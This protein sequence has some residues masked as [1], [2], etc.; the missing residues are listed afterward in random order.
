MRSLNPPASTHQ[1]PLLVSLVATRLVKDLFGVGITHTY[2]VK[3]GK[4][5]LRFPFQ[6]DG[7][8]L[9]AISP[10]QFQAHDGYLELTFERESDKITG[11]IA[12][13]GRL[14]PILF[15]RFSG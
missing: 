10:D 9:T 14:R 11:L 13:S 8:Q 7:L 3:D 12:K 6:K 2:I 5:E 4:L 1:R 15:K